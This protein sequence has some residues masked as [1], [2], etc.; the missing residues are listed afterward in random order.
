VREGYTYTAYGQALVHTA[1]GNDT[2]WF[3]SD[4]T[5]A[6]TSA[7]A[8]PY[9]YTGRRQDTETGLMQYRWRFYDNDTGVFTSRD[10]LGRTDNIVL[11]LQKLVNGPESLGSGRGS[12]NRSSYLYAGNNPI[13]SLDPYGLECCGRSVE[14]ALY[15]THAKVLNAYD[16]L[17]FQEACSSCLKVWAPVGGYQSVWDMNSLTWE[18]NNS[19]M[20]CGNKPTCG[21]DDQDNR[22]AQIYGRCYN[23]WDVNFLLYGWASSACGLNFSEMTTRIVLWKTVGKLITTHKMDIARLPGA[24]EFATWG[25]LGFDIGLPL[26]APVYSQCTR[27][28]EVFPYDLDASWPHK[29]TIPKPY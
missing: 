16:D 21:Q 9:T 1:P 18:W 22:T 8:N 15:L 12:D 24:L 7:L 20:R 23:A 6:V 28:N 3:T 5:T 4:D 27:C 26:I 25:W 2:T 10:P 14:A 13:D 11:M 19:S 17:T 29:S